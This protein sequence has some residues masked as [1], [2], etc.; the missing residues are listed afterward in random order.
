MLV[1]AAPPIV[2]VKSKS[3]LIGV[4]VGGEVDRS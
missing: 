1:N 4:V 2:S 3:V